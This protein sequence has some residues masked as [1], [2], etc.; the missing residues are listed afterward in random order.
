MNTDQDKKQHPGQE[1]TVAK[2]HEHPSS[3]FR[4]EVPP[5]E[6]NPAEAAELEQQRKEALTERD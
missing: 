5:S 2:G 1:Q 4:G 3:P 6:P